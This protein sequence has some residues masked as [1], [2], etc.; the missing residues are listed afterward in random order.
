MSHISKDI[1]YFNRKDVIFLPKQQKESILI[2]FTE[3]TNFGLEN[4]SAF[5]LFIIL[6]YLIELLYFCISYYIYFEF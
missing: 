5:L 3:S 6:K 2:Y 4:L 1:R